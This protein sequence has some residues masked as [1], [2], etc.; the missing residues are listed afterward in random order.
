MKK[1]TNAMKT[2][3]SS[4]YHVHKGLLNK[5]AYPHRVSTIQTEV[6]HISWIFLAGLYA[7]KIKKQVKFGRVLDFS[8]LGLRRKYC[9]KEVELNRK[10]CK[11][12]YLGV[13]RLITLPGKDNN[14]VVIAD[15]HTKTGRVIEY[16]VKMKRIALEYRMDRLLA[17]HRIN[18]ENIRKDCF[19]LE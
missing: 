10:L 8:T 12:M 13:V 14:R 11:D 2:I 6:T 19:Y 4:Q 9:Y 15:S 18:L 5:D 16:A 3:F 7:Y 17:A 1:K